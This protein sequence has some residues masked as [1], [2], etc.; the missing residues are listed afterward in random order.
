MSDF[1]SRHKP[2]WEELNRLVTQA[3]KRIGRMSPAELSRLDVLYRRT[4]VHLAQV[5]TRTR[6]EGLTKYLNDLTA[7]AHSIIYLPPRRSTFRRLGSFLV[8]G[9][10]RSVAR[11]WPYH[12]A[13][14]LL[15][16]TGAVAAYLA[17]SSDTAAAYALAMPGDARLPGSTPEQLHEFLTHGRDQ[18]SGEKFV[19][20]SFLF[21]HNLKVGIM[22]LALGVLAAIPTIFLMF[23][24]GMLLGGFTAIHH[25]AGIYA[26]YWAWILPHGVT[27]LLAIVLCGGVGLMLGRAVLNP[28]KL[29]RTESLTRAGNEAAATCL[30]IAVMLLLAAIIESYLRQSHLSNAARFAF[31]GGS[32]LFWIVY[33]AYGAVCERSEAKANSPGE[34]R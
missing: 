18:D 5:S 21:S 31:A 27:E 29:T 7:A 1:I 20:A 32:A 10:A 14:G 24:N 30:G 12:L 13:A 34:S 17:A 15:M 22:A 9:F 19:F 26:D 16:I 11:A 25:G 2:E 28:G 23:Y 3:R 6:D 8:E 33:F 4:T